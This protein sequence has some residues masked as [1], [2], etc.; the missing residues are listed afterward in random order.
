MLQPRP[1]AKPPEIRYIRAAETVH[2]P[3]PVLALDSLGRMHP[4]TAVTIVLATTG[5]V[6]GGVVAIVALVAAVVAAAAAVAGMVA[7]ALVS[8]AVIVLALGGR[9][10]SRP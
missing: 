1:P 8:L 4:A 7:V 10:S 5:L 9:P 3:A 6:V 2:R